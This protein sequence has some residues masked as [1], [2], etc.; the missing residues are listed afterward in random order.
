MIIKTAPDKERARSLFNM[1]KE[2]E[3][4]TYSIDIEKFPTIVAESY[5]ETIKELMTALSLYDGFKAIGENAHK[6]LID[7]MSNYK[8]LTQNEIFLIDDL[9]IRRNKSLYEGRKIEQ[10]YVSNNKDKLISIINKLKEII[11]IRLR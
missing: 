7:Y 10:S 1:V 5:Y 6:D 4:F 2:R 11:Q 8:E 9:R 3:T